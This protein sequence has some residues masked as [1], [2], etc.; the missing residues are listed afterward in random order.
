MS[1]I[2]GPKFY[3]NR[4]DLTTLILCMVPLILFWFV[5]PAPYPI[6]D[7]GMRVLGVFITCI[8]FL[9]FVDTAWPVIF[10]FILM[11]RTGVFNLHQV[12]ASAFGAWITMFVIMSFILAKALEET[13]FTARMARWV[14]GLKF[15]SK[16][17][18][19]FTFSMMMLGILC[20]ALMNQVPATAFLLALNKRILRS[21][22]YTSQ[23][24]YS[25]LLTIVMVFGAIL[26]GIWTPMGSS[27]IVL[28]MGIFHAA[29]GETMTFAQYLAFSTPVTFVIVILTCIMLRAFIRP[30]FSKFKDFDVKNMMDENKPA[31]LREKTVVAIFFGTVTLWLLPGILSIIAPQSALAIF[32]GEFPITFWALLAVVLMAVIRI[33]DK[34]VIPF[35]KTIE[36][37][38]AWGIVFFVTNGS[39]LGAAVVNPAVGLQAFIVDRLSPVLEAMG[40][41]GIMFVLSA[42]LIAFTQ[43]GASITAVTVFGGVAMTLSATGVIHPM[44]SMMLVAMLSAATFT[45]PSGFAPI[46]M[47]HGDEFSNTARV[48]KYG[49]PIAIITMLS[50]V[51]VGYPIAYALFGG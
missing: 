33:D 9:T 16:S 14:L 8:L 5:L 25:H 23:D 18:W 51:F 4:K 27:I 11:S 45:F 29:T 49:T 38:F 35:K 37:K 28:G 32:L 10:C 17:P 34:P 46:A 40:P 39:F 43:I 1:V 13:G 50:A 21:M 19:A 15:T 36:D 6:T 20:S 2:D 31:D 7:V 48:Y 41:F 24:P 44:V 22:G 26:G 3:M 42:V 30:D 47:L 12:I